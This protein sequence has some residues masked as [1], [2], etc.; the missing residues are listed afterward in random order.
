M[1]RIIGFF[2]FILLMAE[3]VHAEPSGEAIRPLELGLRFDGSASVYSFESADDRPLS[4]RFDHARAPHGSSQ[5]ADRSADKNTEGWEF[6]LAPYM[7]MAGVQ[8]DSAMGPFEASGDADSIDRFVRRYAT[9]MF[10]YFRQRGKSRE[11][12]KDLVQDVMYKL[13]TG[14]LLAT[15]RL[16]QHKFRSYLL[17]V[18]RNQGISN[19]RKEPLPEQWQVSLDRVF[20]E[21]GPQLEPA[22]YETP[23]DAFIRREARQALN[24]IIHQLQEEICE[25]ARQGRPDLSVHFSIFADRFLSSWSPGEP[26][27]FRNTASLPGAGLSGIR[28]LD[29]WASIAAKHGVSAGRARTMCRT[30]QARMKRILLA[31]FGQEDVFRLVA[32]F[33]RAACWK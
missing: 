8:A 23:E 26:G 1:S 14:K 27:P 17:A 12:A 21:A 24:E 18:L 25:E 2:A 5:D 3:G 33:A 22:G 13:A 20:E 29:C 9:P 15:V 28:D 4:L 19:G 30:V 6:Q 16:R 32:V 10:C 7:W 31:E 11:D